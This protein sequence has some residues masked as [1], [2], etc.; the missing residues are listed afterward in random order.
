MG[1]QRKTPPDAPL[2]GRR[3][4]DASRMV[5]RTLRNPDRRT[6][7]WKLFTSTRVSLA[8]PWGGLDLMP[9]EA[10]ELLDSAAELTVRLTLRR[11]GMFQVEPSAGLTDNT[12]DVQHLHNARQRVLRDLERMRQRHKVKDSTP[13]A[14]DY[15]RSRSANGNGHAGDD[16]TSRQAAAPTEPQTQRSE[17]E[18]QR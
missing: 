16:R 13:S 3:P 6:R 15:L 18:A 2:P 11:A 17:R 8:A 12:R 4:K 5:S 10:L 7:A 1:R 14:R 9:P